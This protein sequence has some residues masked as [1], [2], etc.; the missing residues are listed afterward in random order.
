MSL[1]IEIIT[2]DCH[3]PELLSSFW[4]ETLAWEVAFES[5]EDG[6][7]GIRGETASGY[8]ELLFI[9]VPEPKPT[10]NRWHL[11]LRPDDQSAEVERLERLG[12]K[13]VDI[14]QEDTTWVVMA[15]PEG[16]EFCVLRPKRQ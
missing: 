1:S 14:G 12:A 2:V 15:D 9:R 11:D 4:A 13:R 8:Q 3:D 6:E 7:V 16:N 10:K 5:E